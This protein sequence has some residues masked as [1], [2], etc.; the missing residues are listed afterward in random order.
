MI[1]SPCVNCP[2]IGCGS[3]HD[4]CEKFKEF[5]RAIDERNKEDR[6]NK[7]YVSRKYRFQREW[8]P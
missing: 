6:K 3:K 5:Q 4:T 1:H 8:K 2:E 7:E